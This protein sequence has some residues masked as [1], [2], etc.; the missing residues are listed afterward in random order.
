MAH[1]C[2]ATGCKNH[3]P[4]EMF[5]C[6]YHWFRLRNY[7]RAAIWSTYR[8]GQCDDWNISQEYSN[9][10]KAA[11]TYLAKLEGKEPD[12]KIY[13]MLEPKGEDMSEEVTVIFSLKGN[14]KRDLFITNLTSWIADANDQLLDPA[15]PVDYIEIKIIIVDDEVKE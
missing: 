6:R 15:D 1:T 10:A 9:A 14:L 2:H 3:V 13:D 12:I 5:M 8:P 7:H 11:I 4:P